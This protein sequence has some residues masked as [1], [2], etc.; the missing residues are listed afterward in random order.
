MISGALFFPGAGAGR[1]TPNLVAVDRALVEALDGITVVRA[2][3]PYRKEGRRS[4]D[5]PAKAVAAVNEEAV[6]L[7]AAVGD[8]TTAG[9][10]LGGRSF[11][12]RMCSL[13]V[14]EGLPA[15]GLALIA[16][17]LHPP[18]KPDRLRTEHFGDLDLPCLFVSGTSDPF[19]SPDELE[20][21]AAAIPGPVTHAWIDGGRHDL[22]GADRQVADAVVAWARAL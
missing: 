1:D 8:D 18:G 2:D 17:P 12:G 19:G 22:R 20:A 5:R 16:Y 21:Q 11:G 6:A 3:F 15:A 4:P 14:A 10:V 7:A 9:L 13:A